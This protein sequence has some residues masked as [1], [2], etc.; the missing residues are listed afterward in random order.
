MVHS[1]IRKERLYDIGILTIHFL[2]TQW[3]ASFGQCVVCAPKSVEVHIFAG[4][5]I[6]KIEV[7]TFCH[8]LTSH[9]CSALS[10]QTEVVEQNEEGLVAVIGKVD[11]YTQIDGFLLCKRER[12]AAGGPVFHKH[13]LFVRCQMIHDWQSLRGFFCKES[14]AEIVGLSRSRLAIYRNSI[15]SG[16]QRHLLRNRGGHGLMCMSHIIS[17]RP[18]RRCS[19]TSKVVVG[20]LCIGIHQNGSVI[21]IW[22]CAIDH[23]PVLRSCDIILAGPS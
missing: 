20:G 15:V 21:A 19:R 12:H 22:S 23:T 16:W 11:S 9:R 3:H 14:Q 13:F 6:I 4:A 8:S 18:I 5:H 17:I 1:L 2:E 10:S 7:V